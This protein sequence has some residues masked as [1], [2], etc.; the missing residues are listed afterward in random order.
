MR[1]CY[2]DVGYMLWEMGYRAINREVE[3]YIAE[4][5]EDVDRGRE[6]DFIR[7]L[8]GTVA[9]WFIDVVEEQRAY[10]EENIPK[11]NDFFNKYLAGKSWKDIKSDEGLMSDWEFYS[12]WYKDCYGFRP[13][14][15]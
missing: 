9:Y 3:S 15:Y 7:H 8:I 11:L 13:H 6:K 1:F 4:M 5:L 2:D 12:D 10:E 14:T